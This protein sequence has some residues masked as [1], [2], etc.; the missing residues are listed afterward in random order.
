MEIDGFDYNLI[1]KDY[2]K[3]PELLK[4]G[5]L[6]VAKNQKVS[7]N[8]Y[9]QAI[10][11][12]DL[13]EEDYRDYLDYLKSKPDTF[14]HRE[15]VRR[16]RNELEAAMQEFYYTACDIRVL[17]ARLNHENFDGVDEL[18]YRNIGEHCMYMCNFRSLCQTT[19]EGGNVSLV[20]NLTYKNKEVK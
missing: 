3:V 17:R 1:A 19:I 5:G 10:A 20:R 11:K 4:K 13:N 18:T 12:Y 6:S 9:K 16:N 8:T 15:N 7:Y 14:L 2:P